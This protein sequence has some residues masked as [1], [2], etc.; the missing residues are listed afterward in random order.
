MSTY[1]IGDVH[2]CYDE[3]MLLLGQIRFNRGRDR[4]VFVGDLV[5]RGGQS[6][7]VLR[8][9]HSL[10]SRA[11]MVLGNHDISLI[12]YAYGVY[13]GRGTDFSRI[14]QAGDSLYLIEW[15]RRQPLL[16]ED[17]VNNIIVTHAGIPPRWSLKKAKKQARKAEKKLRGDKVKKYLKRAYQGGGEQWR[18]DFDKYDKF[19]YRI[20]GFTRLRY[21][22]RRGEPDF[23]DKCPVG[24]QR[25]GLQPWFERRRQQQNDGQTRVVFG[26]WAALGY[27][28][29]ANALCLD[30]GCVWGG[31]LTAV[32][33]TEKGIKRVQIKAGKKKP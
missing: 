29:T 28:Q 6:I 16:I 7:E 1:F 3:L 18:A 27:R 20:N 12:A 23:S 24:Q 9:I 5:N 19:R 31:H 22:N 2:G 13:H 30:S 17:E 4:L 8:F 14:M 11:Q 25:P 15:L 26:H 10:G 32:S 21:C 33:F